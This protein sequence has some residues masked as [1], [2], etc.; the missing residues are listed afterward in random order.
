MVSITTEQIDRMVEALGVTGWYLHEPPPLVPK[1]SLAG[2]RYRL[3]PEKLR[4]VMIDTHGIVDSPGVRREWP[5]VRWLGYV[6]GYVK[7][8]RE[9]VDWDAKAMAQRPKRVFPK[10][11]D[12]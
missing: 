5:P 6:M 11:E 8:D 12:V 3:K 10:L 9:P 1:K 7:E 2:R 4:T